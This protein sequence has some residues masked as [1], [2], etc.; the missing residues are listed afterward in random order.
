VAIKPQ[1]VTDA[2]LA[3]L[4]LLWDRGALTAREIR[5]ELYPSDT[6][7]NHGTI[8]KLL[9]RLE[10]KKLVGRDRSSFVHVFKPLISR[11]D[12]AGRQ[13]DALA[14]KLTEGSLVPFI[15]HA[16]G[17]RK[18]SAKDREQIR[19]MLENRRE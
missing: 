11:E 6:P 14:E 2:E 12:L 8:Q 3:V 10:A 4:Q 13:L 17:S 9:Q 15:L 5:E 18:L 19:R 7:S 1:Q 16:V